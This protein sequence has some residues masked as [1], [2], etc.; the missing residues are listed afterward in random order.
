MDEV[1]TPWCLTYDFYSESDQAVT[2]RDR[3][4][5]VQDRVAIREVADVIHQRL[6]D[7]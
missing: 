7:Y 4:S 3:D 6:R 1:G 5:L 2:I